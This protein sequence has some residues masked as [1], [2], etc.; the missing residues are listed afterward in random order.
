MATITYPCSRC[1]GHC[2]ERPNGPE[3]GLCQGEG[4]FVS[5]QLGDR[6]AIEP[7]PVCGETRP[8]GD[9]QE[10][11]MPDP[12]IC[13]WCGTRVRKVECENEQLWTNLVFLWILVEIV[14][15]W[16]VVGVLFVLGV[17]W[18][19][20]WAVAAVASLGTIVTLF[21]MIHLGWGDEY[22]PISGPIVRMVRLVRGS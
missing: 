12:D 4:Q 19:G 10:A 17:R 13:H 15:V 18:L 8:F 2:I 5:Y 1:Y 7:C 22:G 11:M 9:A 14:A 16:L 21:A 3:C 20:W 6:P